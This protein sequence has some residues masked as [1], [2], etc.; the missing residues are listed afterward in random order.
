MT[1]P[2]WLRRGC[3]TIVYGGRARV[4]LELRVARVEQSLVPICVK[5]E[6]SEFIH[7]VEEPCAH[8]HL[9]DRL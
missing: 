3:L 6:T 7:D 9:A 5:P 2:P 4:I 8:R 1:M